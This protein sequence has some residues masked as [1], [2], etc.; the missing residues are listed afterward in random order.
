MKSMVLAFF[1]MCILQEENSKM[2]K[3]IQK[4][5]KARKRRHRSDAEQK[6][7]R[8]SR[9]GRR[10]RREEDN[11]SGVDDADAL[12]SD[13]GLAGI[14]LPTTRLPHGD[15]VMKAEDQYEKKMDQYET[16]MDQYEK[17]MDQYEK[18]GQYEKM[19]Q[20][21]KMAADLNAIIHLLE[22]L[23]QQEINWEDEADTDNSA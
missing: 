13:G 21:E 12:P 7:K 8:T 10:S 11:A 22:S 15:R 18:M 20:Y 16:K 3:K 17:K 14:A 4:L 2:K 23:P 9:H 5:E 19:D 1:T 6:G